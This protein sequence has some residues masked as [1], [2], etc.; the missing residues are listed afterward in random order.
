MNLAAFTWYAFILLVQ[1]DD[2]I[3]N[4]LSCSDCHQHVLVVYDNSIC[5]F[6]KCSFIH[7]FL[8]FKACFVSHIFYAPG[9]SEFR[10]GIICDVNRLMI[11]FEKQLLELLCCEGK[12]KR[13][14]WEGVL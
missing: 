8:F 7:L 5:L 14:H 12:D 1:Q 13:A 11:T 6:P 2:W 10:Q 9:A 3:S 4:W